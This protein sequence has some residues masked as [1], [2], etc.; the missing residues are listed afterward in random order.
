MEERSRVERSGG[1]EGVGG[2]V[3]VFL[4][5]LGNEVRGNCGL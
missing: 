4:A 1:E 2:I 3:L 5:S